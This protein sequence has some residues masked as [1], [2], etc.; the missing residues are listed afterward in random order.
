MYTL[1]K[2]Y[3]GPSATTL[4]TFFVHSTVVHFNGSNS[5][6]LPNHVTN[7]T[8]MSKLMALFKMVFDLQCAVALQLISPS[9]LL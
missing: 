8:Q 4:E 1:A 3:T 7:G 2:T 5:T 9:N 6:L